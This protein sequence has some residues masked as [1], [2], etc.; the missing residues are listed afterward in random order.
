MKCKD[1]LPSCQP[2]RT[3]E[4]YIR[5]F[6]NYEAHS[7]PKDMDLLPFGLELERDDHSILSYSAIETGLCGYLRLF[8]LSKYAGRIS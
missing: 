5:N 4:R 7:L 2:L 6:E 8:C 1:M 3:I